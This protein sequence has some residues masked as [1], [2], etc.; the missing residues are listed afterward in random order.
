MLYAKL[1]G[2]YLNVPNNKLFIYKFI[3]CLALYRNMS[4]QLTS[5]KPKSVLNLFCGDWLAGCLPER[6]NSILAIL[7]P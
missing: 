3:H 5:L 1:F 2:D 6:M 4:T 7:S